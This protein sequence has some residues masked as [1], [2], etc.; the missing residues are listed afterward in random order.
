MQSSYPEKGCSEHN[1]VGAELR[2]GAEEQEATVNRQPAGRETNKQTC[3]EKLRARYKQNL[4]M[5]DV[6]SLLLLRQTSHSK[7]AASNT[8]NLGMERCLK[9]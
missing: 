7:H 8:A 2:N 6:P 4:Q 3:L 9:G 5:K 1:V